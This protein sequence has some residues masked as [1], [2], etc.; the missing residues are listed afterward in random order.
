M[1][2]PRRLITSSVLAAVLGTAVLGSSGCGGGD[3]PSRA[4][5]TIDLPKRET[6]RVVAKDAAKGKG[7][8]RPRGR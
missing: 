2:V 6:A 7:A 3:N 5:G 1:P 4:A 8:A